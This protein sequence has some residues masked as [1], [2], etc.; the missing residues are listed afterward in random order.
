MLSLMS[1]TCKN[2]EIQKQ[3]CEY[4]NNVTFQIGL[5]NSYLLQKLKIVFWIYVISDLNGEEIIRTFYEKELQKINQ[6]NLG[7]EK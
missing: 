6:K 7:Y 2:I 3:F 5:K 4:K 1:V